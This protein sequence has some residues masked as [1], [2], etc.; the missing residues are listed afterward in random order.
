VILA[1]CRP[2]VGTASRT[3]GAKEAASVFFVLLFSASVAL[4]DDRPPARLQRPAALVHASVGMLGLPAASICP[5]PN[6]PCQPGEASLAVTLMSLVRFRQFAVG[7]ATQVAFGLRTEAGA[8]E[9]GREHARNYFTFDAVFRYYLPPWRRLDWW[10]G[11]TTGAVVLTDVWSTE[12]D[13]N[14][15]S[16]ARF[17][18]PKRLALRS[19]GITFGPLIGAHLR[20]AERWLIGTQFRYCNWIFPGERRRTP[21]GDSSSLAG[22]IDA[23]EFGVLLGFRIGL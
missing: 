16:D 18:G 11:A 23:L 3:K 19:E 1:H 7:A 14:P 10:V 2:L 21:L 8:G 12:S 15:Y 5:T 17:V 22:R 6:N 4:A 20:F 9:P 13:R